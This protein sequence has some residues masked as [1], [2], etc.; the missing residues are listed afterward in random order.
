MTP[1][2][3]CFFSAEQISAGKINAISAID[4]KYF[5]T[6]WDRDSWNALFQGHDRMLCLASISEE[7]V[8]FTL[9]DFSVVDSFAHL[10]K[11]LTLPAYQKQGL[12][13]ELLKF[14]LEV[15]ETEKKIEHFFLEVEHANCSAVS[16][17]K[18]CGFEVIHTK[19]DF[20]GNAKDAF[21]MTK[22]LTRVI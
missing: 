12:G 17:Y 4:L 13:G 18:K 22:N 6:P 21:V 11:I 14:S 16:L 7:V 5:P 20:Y 3:E 8:G 9:F 1:V 10:L 19:K 15:L 2:V